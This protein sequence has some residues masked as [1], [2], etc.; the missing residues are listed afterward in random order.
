[1]SDTAVAEPTNKELSDLIDASFNEF[2]EGTIVNGTI[3]NIGPQ[4]VMVDIGYKSEGAIF[5]NEFEDE[6]I[7]VGDE[8]EVLL[9]KLEDDDGMVVLS[10]EKAAYRQNW[11]KIVAVYEAGG[12]VKGKVKSVVKGGMSGTFTNSKSLKST[13]S[14]RTSFFHAVR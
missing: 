9:E 5:S 2:K 1:M 14:V 6:D 4:V 13:M 7:E 12:L 8:I 10:K 11:D 3:L